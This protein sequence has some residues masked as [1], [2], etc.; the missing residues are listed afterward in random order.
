MRTVRSIINCPPFAERGSWKCWVLTKKGREELSVARNVRTQRTGG[1]KKKKG[2]QTVENERRVGTKESKG[3]R[4]ENEE[5][6]KRAL[7]IL[8]LD[9]SSRVR[10]FR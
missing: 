4:D 5:V 8:R 10:N 2:G 7:R 6:R 3:V 9:R 1:R